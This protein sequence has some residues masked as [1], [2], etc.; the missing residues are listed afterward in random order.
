VPGDLRPGVVG[1]AEKFVVIKAFVLVSGVTGELHRRL[2][3][4]P[5]VGVTGDSRREGLEVEVVDRSEGA[6][7]SIN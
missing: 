6:G 5:G 3:K 2:V 1:L 7:H 4:G